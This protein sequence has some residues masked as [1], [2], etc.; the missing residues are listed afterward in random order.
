M[1]FEIPERISSKIIPEPN[2]GCWLWLGAVDGKGYG[3]IKITGSRKNYPVHRMLFEL[4]NGSIS[5]ELVVD[6]KCRVR[7]CCNPQHLEAVTNK[8]NILRGTSPAATNAAK[9]ICVNGHSLDDA[10]IVRFVR[11]CRSCQLSNMA[12]YYKRKTA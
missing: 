1:L 12:A 6:H 10:Y 11:K 8:T 7:C 5:P 9:Q 3:R 2:S 4:S